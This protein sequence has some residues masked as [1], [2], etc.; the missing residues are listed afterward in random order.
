M[1]LPSAP[2][3]LLTQVNKECIGGWLSVE[4]H[5]LWWTSEQYDYFSQQMQ[6]GW[7]KYACP[8]GTRDANQDLECGDLEA[9]ATLAPPCPCRLS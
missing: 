7:R 3:E 8:L 4:R 5:N 6:L 2:K 1:Y 9:L